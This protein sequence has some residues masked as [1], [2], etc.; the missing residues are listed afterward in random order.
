MKLYRIETPDGHGICQSTGNKLC[1]LYWLACHDETKHDDFGPDDQKAARLCQSPFMIFAF[2]SLDKLR[3]WFPQASGRKLMADHGARGVIYEADVK[4]SNG[5]Q[6]I[7]DR[8]LATKVGEF[9]L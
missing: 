3:E 9:E 4:L 5:Y 2:P 1:T 7:F 8:R 6:V